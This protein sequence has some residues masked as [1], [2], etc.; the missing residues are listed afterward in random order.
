MKEKVDSQ[1][2]GLAIVRTQREFVWIR[3]YVSGREVGIINLV[4]ELGRNGRARDQGSY[5]SALRSSRGCL[6]CGKLG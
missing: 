4:I 6:G 1:V 2:P 5:M 3:L